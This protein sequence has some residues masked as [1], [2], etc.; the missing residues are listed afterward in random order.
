MRSCLHMKHTNSCTGTGRLQVIAVGQ[1][2]QGKKGYFPLYSMSSPLDV[3]QQIH[4]HKLE[5]TKCS[6]QSSSGAGVSKCLG[7]GW[8]LGHGLFCP[9]CGSSVFCSLSATQKCPSLPTLFY[10]LSSNGCS[11]RT[12]AHIDVLA[13]LTPE[14]AQTC[15]SATLMSWHGRWVSTSTTTD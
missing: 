2:G 9:S 7:Q 5:Q 10:I 3:H 13:Q 15:F 12:P 8:G 14:K 1:S 6:G 4:W 11:A